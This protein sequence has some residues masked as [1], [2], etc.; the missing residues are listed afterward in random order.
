MMDEDIHSLQGVT[1]NAEWHAL[2]NG[3]RRIVTVVDATDV[4]DEHETGVIRI[5][6]TDDQLGE[7]DRKVMSCLTIEPI[8][9]QEVAGE[10]VIHVVF[11]RWWRE[12]VP[13]LM[14]PDDDKRHYHYEI[15]EAMQGPVD[16]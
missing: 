1:L 15:I 13:F 10:H 4:A 3:L 9:R 5:R 7:V 6:C 16:H 14:D 2:L 8:L 11:R 12:T